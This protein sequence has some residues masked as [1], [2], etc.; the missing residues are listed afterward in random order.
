MLLW[1]F[2]ED[3]VEGKKGNNV[4]QDIQLTEASRTDGL[5]SQFKLFLSP[6]PFPISAMFFT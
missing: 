3:I 5:L 4:I 1:D 6:S 2:S